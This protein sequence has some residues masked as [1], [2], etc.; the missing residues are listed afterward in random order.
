MVELSEEIIDFVTGATKRK[1]LVLQAFF[2]ESYR[3]REP[4]IMCVAG[5]IGDKD[6]WQA[7]N[8]QWGKTL[9]CYG[10][11]C[12]HAKD[13][14]CDHL[15]PKL[16]ELID[17]CGLNG[18]TVS[19]DRKEYKE[20]CGD[21]MKT[22]ISSDYGFCAVVCAFM[23]T[24]WAKEVSAGPVSLI[25]EHGHPSSDY[26]GSLLRALMNY[27]KSI[28]GAMMARKEDFLPLQ[29]ADF[30][31]HSYSRDNLFWFKELL[32]SGRVI[33]RQA[34]SDQLKDLSA[35]FAMMFAESRHE[36]RKRINAQKENART[37]Q[38]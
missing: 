18:I 30:L 11:E 24:R 7:F 33:H 19:V 12:F 9:S 36:K 29:A 31:A 35:Q 32:K 37:R 20:V 21:N 38:S 23:F 8:T 15:R 10:V 4:L 34:T 27:D 13:R 14:E 25:Y 26:I 3:H 22:V 2:D 28:A 6:Q 16:L 17:A 1:L 5:F